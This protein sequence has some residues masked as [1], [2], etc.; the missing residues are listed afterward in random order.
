[1]RIE[2]IDGYEIHETQHI[3]TLTDT[4]TERRYTTIEL[5]PSGHTARVVVNIDNE[6]LSMDMMREL[7][8]AMR[9]ADRIEWFIYDYTL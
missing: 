3:F 8:T 1:M 2:I 7:E 4:A 5:D 6:V 9:I